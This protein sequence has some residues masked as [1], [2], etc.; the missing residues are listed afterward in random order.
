M[1]DKQNRASCV[2]GPPSVQ[3]PRLTPRRPPPARTPLAS[4]TTSSGS[5]R[6]W[7]SP[8]RPPARCLYTRAPIFGGRSRRPGACRSDL[9]RRCPLEQIC[10][11]G[12]PPTD[13]RLFRR[14]AVPASSL[15]LQRFAKTHPE[16]LR[17]PSKPQSP[18]E[19]TIIPPV[20]ID[21]SAMV[22]PS[23][24]IGPNV[25]LGACQVARG[26]HARKFPTNC[27]CTCRRIPAP[28]DPMSKSALASASKTAC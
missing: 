28:Q 25:S 21:P 2:A 8:S 1:Q 14:S 17:A 9:G 15:Y 22:D 26:P 3:A 19:P 11:A 13:T 12:I 16:L 24:K 23:A 7:S 4:T 5:S 27:D 10:A 20:S 6:T 18:N